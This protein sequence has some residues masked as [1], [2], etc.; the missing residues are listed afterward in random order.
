MAIINKEQLNKQLDKITIYKNEEDIIL[1]ELKI[2]LN[3]CESLYNTDNQEKISDIKLELFEKL[4]T[5]KK[6][7]NNYIKVI[8]KTIKKYDKMSNKSII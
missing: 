2:K 1:G 3:S 5:I 8:N 4:D 6:N 7:H